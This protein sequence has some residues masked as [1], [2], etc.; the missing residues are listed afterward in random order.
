MNDFEK[1]ELR[2]ISSKRYKTLERKKSLK[3]KGSK[4]IKLKGL[5]G[6]KDS[7]R[8]G[9]TPERREDKLSFLEKENDEDFDSEEDEDLTEAEKVEQL[10]DQKNFEFKI[11]IIVK[12]FF[13]VVLCG[14]FYMFDTKFDTFFDQYLENSCK[15]TYMS[16]LILNGGK[17]D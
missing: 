1:K 11:L 6:D 13:L 2:I 10:S 4:K 15:F 16:H 8:D 7:E 12:V 5:V 14:L 9:L 3:S 17:F